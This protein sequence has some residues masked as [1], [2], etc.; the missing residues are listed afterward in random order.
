MS[1]DINI[2][3]KAVDEASAAIRNV[4]DKL[5]VLDQTVSQ[6]AAN[7]SGLSSIMRTA[8]GVMLGEV[9]RDALGAVTSS[10]SEAS[11][12][13]ADLEWT[14]KTIVKASGETGQAAEQLYQ[15]L[16]NVAHAQTTLGYTSV[17]AAAALESLVKAGLS[18]A[19]AAQALEAALKMARLEGISTAQASD[20]LVGVMN[21]FGYAANEA[22]QVVDILVNSSVAGVDAASD[23]AL[24]LSYCGGQAASMGFSLEETTAALVAINNQGIAAEKAGRYL[25]SMFADLIAKSDDLGFNIYNTDGSMKSLSEIVDELTDKLES[26][27][28]QAER[29]A[30]LNKVFGSQSRRAALALLNL[31]KGGKKA[32]R[33]LKDLEKAMGKTGTATD[34]I[35]DLMNTAKG[36]LARLEAEVKNAS[37]GLGEMAL[38]IELGWKQFALA[39]GPIGAVADAL[40]PSLLQGAISGVMMALPQLIASMG[41]LTGI[42]GGVKGAFAALN[43][44]MMAN[45]IMIIVAAIGALIAILVTAYQTCEPFRNAVNAVGSALYNFLK[46]AIEAISGALQWLWNNVLGP[47]AAFLAACFIVQWKMLGAA[48]EW[49]NNNVIQ[50]L[51]GAIKWLW[52]HVLAPLA[53]FI[54]AYFMIQFQALGAVLEWLNVHVVQPLTGAIQWFWN[55]V[56]APLAMFIASTFIATWNALIGVWEA[57]QAAWDALCNGIK[58]AWENIIEP[59]Y[60]ALKG[61][62]DTLNGAVNSVQNALGGFTDAV[63]GAMGGA[64]DAIGGFISSICFAHAIHEAVESSIGDLERWVGAVDD[65]MREGSRAVK[66]FVGDVGAPKGGFG[67]GV[68]PSGPVT[69]VINVTISSPLVH[70]EGSA[71]RKTAELAAE[72]IEKKLRNVI[73]EA[74]S[75]GAP[76]THKRIRLARVI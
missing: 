71:D 13:V 2:V 10:A 16:N 27:G 62:V 64:A 40:G 17:E 37:E 20:M 54:A 66:E 9:A 58:W 26:F 30:Y 31:G 49:L 53:A 28:T 25:G 60:N 8:A 29:D 56:L 22:S 69:S 68:T 7:T 48:L 61:F 14:L 74:S 50:P 24:A 75:S 59:V 11:K 39:L 47:L 45:P 41:G 72:L 1:K 38:Q 57:L 12:Q 34:T 32:G 76:A 44:V 18:G 5:D 70:V 43:A 65:S 4:A 52:D 35:N 51:T 19:D 33:A 6:V 42:L 55:H 73:V 67:V 23:F 63:S 46:P 36:R 21:Q 3:I 15:E